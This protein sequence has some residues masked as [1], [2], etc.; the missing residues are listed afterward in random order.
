MRN[1]YVDYLRGVSIL[2]VLLIHFMIFPANFPGF[3]FI[4]RLSAGGYAGV[5]MFFL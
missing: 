2:I 3:S 5:T 1:P 4:Q